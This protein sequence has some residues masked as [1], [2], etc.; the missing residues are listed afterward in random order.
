MSEARG[1]RGGRPRRVAAGVAFACALA[2]GAMFAEAAPPSSP[3][4]SAP[5]AG[6]ASPDASTTEGEA[7]AESQ[8]AAALRAAQDLE[9]QLLELRRDLD[10]FSRERASYDELRRR[11]DALDARRAPR[12]RF[13]DWASL[14]GV[15]DGVR[16]SGNGFVVRSPDNR[17]LMRPGLRLQTVYEG[18]HARGTSPGEVVPDLSTLRLAHAELLFEGH[19][20]APAFEYRFELDFADTDTGIVKDAFVQW[21]FAPAVALRAG[22]LRVPLGLQATTWN[23]YLEFVDV[24]QPTAAFSLDRD[25]GLAVVGRPFGGRLQYQVAVLDGRRAPC[26]AKPTDQLSCDAVD[27]AYAAR[28]VA[29]PL[30]PLPLFEGDGERHAHPLFSVGVSGS[31]GLVPT[32][33]RARTGNT[34]APLDVDGDFLV[35]NVSVWQAAAE[36]RAIFRGA[37][38]QAEWLGRRE[39]PGSG[40]PERSFWGAYAQASCFVIARRLQLAARVSRGD[41]PLYG[42]PLADRLQQGTRTTEESGAVSF[43]ARGHDAKVQLDYTHRATPDALAATS[44]DRVRLAAQLAF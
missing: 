6:A 4:S 38:L 27:L 1:S 39:H 43:Y 17:F 36:L 2:P 3:P 16:F 37:A 7:R 21:R 19:A 13:D 28:F 41:Q 9:I 22:R 26:P 29:A 25:V 44:E 14:P 24:A 35:D 40:S 10:A 34:A 23:G 32:D 8:G 30:G 15:P 11:L 12:G 5:V 18:V 20:G 42:L 31:Y 33:V